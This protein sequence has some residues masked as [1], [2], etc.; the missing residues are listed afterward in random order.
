LTP[1]GQ[2]QLR[3]ATLHQKESLSRCFT[4]LLAS[5][6]T[7]ISTSHD[8]V[9]TPCCQY[10]DHVSSQH[11]CGCCGCCASMGT[12]AAAAAHCGYCLCRNYCHHHH[13]CSSVLI[14]LYATATQQQPSSCTNASCTR[15][16]DLYR[17][18]RSTGLGHVFTLSRRFQGKK[19]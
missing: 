7:I 14:L 15:D 16:G 18:G 12:T 6:S 8:A 11:H 13:H 2:R 5:T 17:N 4:L 9:A 1:V 10:S 19:R 3:E